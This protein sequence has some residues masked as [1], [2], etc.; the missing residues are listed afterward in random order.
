MPIEVKYK[1]PICGFES[2][3][4]GVCPTDDENMQK[5]CYCGSGKYST[6]CCSLYDK[7]NENEKLVEA[8]AKADELEEELKT[9]EIISDEEENKNIEE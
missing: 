1:C 7:S 4:P 3:A 8:E 2:N 5:L 6:D 9:A